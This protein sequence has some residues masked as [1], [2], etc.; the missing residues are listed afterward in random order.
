RLKE[1]FFAAL[2]LPAGERAAAVDA[3]LAEDT[4]LGLRL[5]AM[6]GR[7]DEGTDAAFADLRHEL[8][9]ASGG[10]SDLT[11]RRLGPWR[12]E[13]VLA[14]GGMGRVYLAARDDATY[15]QQ[16]AVKLLRTALPTPELLARFRRERQALADLAHPAIARL[17]DGGETAEGWPYLVLEYID[18]EPIDAHVRRVQ[19]SLA[20][21]LRLFLAV[22]DGVAHAHRALIVHRDLKPGNILVARAGNPKLLDF[23]IA[24]LLADEAA[25]GVTR[26]Y[27]R[28]LTP[29]YAAPEQLLGQPVT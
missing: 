26:T 6:L 10:E 20:E 25:A 4:E 12:I 3:A 19:P 23:G 11:G 22:C 15:R 27:D 8:A 29:Q 16:A 7:H 14:E 28:V 9:A 5:R 1:L 18:G 24:K 2:D 13:R 17:L 21:R